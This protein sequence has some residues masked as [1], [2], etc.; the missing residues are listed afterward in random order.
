MNIE[1]R[2]VGFENKG[3]ELMLRAILAHYSGRRD[4]RFVV[5]A[6]TGTYEQRARYGLY[7][8]LAVPRLGLRGRML[9]LVLHQSYRR[10]Y[11]LVAPGEISAVL[12]ASGYAFGDPWGEG[13]ARGALRDFR[14]ARR[15]GARI[16]LLPQAFGPFG[17]ARL[18]HLYVQIKG[19]A[20][21][22]Y[23][24]DAVSYRH[25]VTCGG[26]SDHVSVAP[27]ITHLVEGHLPE[28][29]SLPPHSAAI[30]PNSM[31]L[32]ADRNR[33]ATY[34]G[35]L[36]S[37]CDHLIRR[38]FTPILLLHE[39]R[40]DRALVARIYEAGGRPLPTICEADPVVLKGILGT[41]TLVFASRYHALVATLSQG[42]PA[43]AV[44]WA[45]KYDELFS[46]YGIPRLCLPLNSDRRRVNETLELLTDDDARRLLTKGIAER[47]EV[48]RRKVRRMWK[49][50]DQLLFG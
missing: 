20:D 16:A 49:E 40:E 31:I 29:R 46:D 18:R 22:V 48:N 24:R 45:H 9:P 30:V 3:A 12:D 10:R 13:P 32:K 1:I 11:G 33:A 25:A 27:D 42:V 39:Q 38:G 4:I 19:T 17:D 35:M 23:A 34:F 6:Y 36:R 44:G 14:E 37:V 43:A 26:R 7:T 28:G 50:V 8:R 2:G 21:L 15:H 47:A 5:S 41:A